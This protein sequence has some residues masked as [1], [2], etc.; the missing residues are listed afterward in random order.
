VVSL[1]NIDNDLLALEKQLSEI[2]LKYPDLARTAASA[3]IAYEI[4][5]ANAIDLITHEAIVADKKLSVAEKDSQATIRS[6]KTM[7]AYRMA[8]AKL[9]G[10]KK[11]IDI[12]QSILMSTQS[13]VKLELIERGL[14]DHRT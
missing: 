12:L 10:V 8:D 1:S 11:Q 14:T 7:E 3:R 4:D 9:D 6:A 2:S 13:R 5:Y